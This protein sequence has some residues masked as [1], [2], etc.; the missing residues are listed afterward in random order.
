VKN[1]IFIFAVIACMASA[2]FTGCSETPEQKVDNAMENAGYAPQAPRDGQTECEAKWRR[3]KRASERT[4]NANENRIVAFK[5]KM[6]EAGPTFKAR[7]R[8]E[9]AVLELR[10]RKLKIL[11]GEYKDGGAAKLEEFRLNFNDNI[12]GVGRSMTALFKDDG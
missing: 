6:E 5:Q 10:N 1:H 3:F 2:C 9:A 4:I 8:S 11:L 7:Y 12:D